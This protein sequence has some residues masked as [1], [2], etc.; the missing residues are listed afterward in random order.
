MKNFIK[1]QSISSFIIAVSLLLG[2]V[3]FILYSVNGS[4]E[5]YFQGTN[6]SK[7]VLLSVFGLIALLGSIVLAQFKFEG[8]INKVVAPT[9]S[10][11]KIAGAI[12][13]I[14]SLIFFITTRAEGLAYI[15]ASND[16]VIQEVQTPANLSSAYVAITGF[17]FYLLSWLTVVV[18]CFFKPIKE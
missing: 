2:I 1:K 17:V 10:I 15:F 14:I 3:A 11:L 12:L 8:T 16:D 7:V 6:E 4:V 9:V 13:L 18:G 5:G